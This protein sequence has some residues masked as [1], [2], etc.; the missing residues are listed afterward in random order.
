FRGELRN[1]RIARIA[2]HANPHVGL[3][4]GEAGALEL[5]RDFEGVEGHRQTQCSFGAFNSR[6][7]SAEVMRTRIVSLSRT[8]CST[9]SLPAGPLA[10]T[11]RHNEA[12][13]EIGSSRTARMRSPG[14]SPVLLAGPRSDKTAT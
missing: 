9:T 10:H 11:R 7:R 8:T 13:L 12:R 3:R 6:V 2:Q 4:L 14:L 5:F 1:I